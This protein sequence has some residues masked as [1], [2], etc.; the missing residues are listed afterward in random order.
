MGKW[1]NKILF[2]M[3]SDENRE[4]PV[5]HDVM[6]AF[7]FPYLVSYVP[8]PPKK[9]W[10]IL[11]WIRSD[12]TVSGWGGCCPRLVHSCAPTHGAAIGAT[13]P[14]LRISDGL[15]AT[16]VRPSGADWSRGGV[17]SLA[18][19]DVPAAPAG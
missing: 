4:I 18:R 15:R 8:P 5:V 14:N 17:M 19:S 2:V 11:G 3:A 7:G 6:A 10:Q 9:N 13:G 1:K 16:R 12:Q